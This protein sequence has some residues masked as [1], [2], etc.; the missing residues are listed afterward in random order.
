MSFCASGA[1]ASRARSMNVAR[2]TVPSRWQCSSTFGRR[3]KNSS[4]D[5]ITALT[6]N[7]RLPIEPFAQRVAHDRAVIQP[8]QLVGEEG[9]A[10]APRARHL[11]D[12]RAPEKAPRAKRLVDFAQWRVDAAVR[13]RVLRVCRHAGRLD[14]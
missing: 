8:R 3:R 10:L 5:L 6:P 13:I 9:D 11:G 1:A 2:R 7:S 14:S 4:I 12:V